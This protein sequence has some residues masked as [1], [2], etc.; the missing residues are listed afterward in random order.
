MARSNYGD[1]MS[2][3]DNNGTLRLYKYPCSSYKSEYLENKHCSGHVTNMCFLYDRHTHL[4]S[5]RT[6]TQRELTGR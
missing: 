3:G 4:S 2:V 5:R 1:Y 6:A